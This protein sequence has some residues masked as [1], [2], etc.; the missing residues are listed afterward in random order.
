MIE[1]H[2]SLGSKGPMDLGVK[3][4]PN[5]QEGCSGNTPGLITCA[6][7]TRSIR[8]SCQITVHSNLTQWVSR[9]DIILYR[10]TLYIYN[11]HKRLSYT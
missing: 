11:V 8:N 9:H 2:N 4:S 10:D 3:Q 7:V 5:G 1:N 6:R